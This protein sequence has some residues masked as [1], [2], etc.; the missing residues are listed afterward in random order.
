[1]KKNTLLI[2]LC[3]A[4][5]TAMAQPGAKFLQG[6]NMTNVSKVSPNGKYAVGYS[7]S[8]QPWGLD[9][10]SGFKSFIWDT[11]AETIN[12]VTNLDETDAAKSRHF[13]DVNDS[14]VVCGYF[15]D[16]SN[17]LT[18]T[19]WGETYT[20]PLNVAA[21]WDADGNITSLG[22]GTYDISTFNNFA[23]GSFATGIS[24]DSKTVVGFISQGNDAYRFPCGWVKNDATGKY[25]FV[26]YSLPEGM[27]GGCVEDVSADGSIAVGWVKKASIQYA[28]YWTSPQNCVLL[29]D[30]TQDIVSGAA[31][32]V[33]ANGK[34]IGYTLDGY[35]PALYVTTDQ[36]V[37]KTR[38][39]DTD[40]GLTISGI[41]DGGDYFGAYHY[42]SFMGGNMYKRMFWF[43]TSND[44]MMDF[45]Y[46]V[47]LW[48]S[49]V[50]MP[51][52]FKPESAESVKASSVSADG[53][54]IAGNSDYG[55]WLMKTQASDIP[56]PKSVAGLKAKVTAEGQITV[57]VQLPK[58]GDV[59]S[60]YTVKEY[61]VYRDGTELA[62]VPASSLKEGETSFAQVDNGVDA[63]SHQYSASVVYTDS[64]NGGA[65]IE[66]PRT[67]P[68]KIQMEGTFAMPF[69]DN[70]D[71]GSTSTNY[72]TLVKEYG[73]TDYQFWGCPMYS[74]IKSTPA[75]YNGVDQQIPYA[76]SM[77]SRHI[78]ATEKKTVYASF[79]RVWS[80][81]NSRDWSLDKDTL[82]FDI[83]TDG[84]SWQTVKDFALCDVPA[85]RWS[86]EYID[87][88]PW[89]AGKLF[90]VRFRVHGQAKAMYLYK[91]D[92]FK[93]AEKPEREAESS[94]LGQVDADGTLHIAWKNSLNAYQLTYMTDPYYNTYNLAIGD[95]GNTIIAANMFTK[96]DLAMYKDKWLTSVY[97][98]IN[99]DTSLEGSK[100]T[101]AA[102]VVFEDGKLVREQEFTPEYN[103]D[104]II[105]LNEPLQIS[106][107]KELKIG[108]K[109]FDYDAR[110]I[111][112]SYFNTL[113][114]VAGKSDIYSQDGGQTWKKLSDFFADV[115]DHELDG[116]AAWQITGNVT[117]KADDAV[118][119]QLDLDRFAAEVYKNGEKITDKWVYLL[120]PGYTDKS[121]VQGDSYQV[122]LFYTDGTCT[123]LSV[124]VVNNGPT[125]I[126]QGALA[127]NGVIY[128]VED[129]KI[130]VEGDVR[131]VSLY[132][133]SGRELASGASRTIGTGNLGKGV[134]V[135]KIEGADGKETSRKVIIK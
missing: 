78:D 48:A 43:S 25:D 95:E 82:S 105:K 74:G 131:S 18:I 46:F 132:D 99:H 134:Y 51:Y 57:T 33:S 77:V 49:D 55:C 88:T 108:I 113:D 53:R 118:P 89:A 28:C 9:N 30:A 19:E 16:P 129:G 36:K 94:V 23:D 32:T 130:S 52:T 64:E 44:M 116:Y 34:Y 38:R 70:F 13:V 115:K 69:Y 31:I 109:I 124:P 122:R 90:Q 15:K 119:T 121:S 135:L 72:W 2:C 37:V 84:D 65:E 10:V 110:Q 76:Y 14:K 106:G 61:K 93:I 40:T 123:E 17:K 91:I 12:W 107:D 100:D 45:D 127:E 7:L 128:A 120:E 21:V 1:M 27:T 6:E 4:A 126:G 11:G 56:L 83:S 50:D 3:L 87:L 5:G 92:E 112:L 66:S 101:H 42:G 68:V 104:Q 8:A 103:T 75:L 79:A 102:V 86:F 85:E 47:K 125:S 98:M 97:T 133:A 59:A 26:S 111:P 39:Y 71:S 63:G 114:F 22:L 62:T 81:I 41:S 73:E 35:E 96:E 80:Y 117:D 24:N 58:P 67:D 29:S 54:I 60:R 20:L